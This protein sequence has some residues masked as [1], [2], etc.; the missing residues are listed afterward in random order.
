MVYLAHEAKTTSGL[1]S[2][3]S[4][5]FSGTD[6]SS[7]LRSLGRLM[8][9]AGFGART[10]QRLGL[11]LTSEVPKTNACLLLDV[12]LPEMNGVEL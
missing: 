4:D 3:I 10:Y 7:V 2:V 9:L 5:H 6:G 12:H 8:R 11:L 1:T